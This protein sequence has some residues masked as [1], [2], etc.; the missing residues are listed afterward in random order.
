MC[1]C[2]FNIINHVQYKTFYNSPIYYQYHNI[3]L[4]ILQITTFYIM[5]F[6]LLFGNAYLKFMASIIS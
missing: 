1:F 5:V 6:F 2:H 4:T 3:K